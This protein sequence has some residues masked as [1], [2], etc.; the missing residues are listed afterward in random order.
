M[1]SF[2]PYLVIVGLF[3]FFYSCDGVHCSNEEYVARAFEIAIQA[4]KNRYEIPDSMPLSRHYSVCYLNRYVDVL[5]NGESFGYD[6][7]VFF[8]EELG[9]DTGNLISMP[10]S[11][12][13]LSEQIISFLDKTYTDPIECKGVGQDFRHS[14]PRLRSES[15][16]SGYLLFNLPIQ[17]QTTGDVYCMVSDYRLFETVVLFRRGDINNDTIVWKP[18]QNYVM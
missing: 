3:L 5:S 12:S 2:I 8:V 6:K 16:V 4:H 13:H 15:N 9:L 7:R 10:I 14:I 11:G 17:D 1:N 18:M